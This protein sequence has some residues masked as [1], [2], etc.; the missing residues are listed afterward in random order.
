MKVI[1]LQE[2]S[3]EGYLYVEESHDG[4]RWLRSGIRER[5]DIGR[6]GGPKLTPDS[7]FV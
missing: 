2:A 1:K 4:Q 5:H 6:G 7:A 3:G